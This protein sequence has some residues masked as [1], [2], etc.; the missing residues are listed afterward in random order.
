MVGRASRADAAVSV[1]CRRTRRCSYAGAGWQFPTSPL[2]DPGRTRDVR[3]RIRYRAKLHAR[4]RPLGLRRVLP[5][6]PSL[7]A[8]D[9]LIL[10][11]NC[12][13]FPLEEPGDTQMR[14]GIQACLAGVV[15]DACW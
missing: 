10:L 11:E 13:Q 4:C 3:Q 14:G 2:R 12:G 5:P 6:A 7:P 9:E 1:Q 15:E 8:K